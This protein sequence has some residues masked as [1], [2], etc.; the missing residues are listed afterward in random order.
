MKKNRRKQ[1]PTKSPKKLHQKRTKRMMKKKAD[2]MENQL[3]MV[4]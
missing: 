2:K 4:S 3:L 1:R